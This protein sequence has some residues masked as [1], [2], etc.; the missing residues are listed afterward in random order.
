MGFSK[1]EIRLTVGQMTV[2]GVIGC[3]IVICSLCTVQSW[4]SSFEVPYLSPE[5]GETSNQEYQEVQ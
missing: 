3:V 2:T 5:G 4:V 1:V